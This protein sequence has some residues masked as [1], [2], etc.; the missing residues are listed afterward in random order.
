MLRER[1][2]VPESVQGRW[3]EVRRV[4]DTP[5]GWASCVPRCSWPDC[6]NRAG[7]LSEDAFRNRPEK[8]SRQSGPPACTYYDRVN[9]PFSHEARDTFPNLS[10]SDHQFVPDSA[11]C[12]FNQ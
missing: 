2:G 6:K 11:K 5:Q 9:F 4:E 8:H 1:R 12:A 10:R 3:C 7:R